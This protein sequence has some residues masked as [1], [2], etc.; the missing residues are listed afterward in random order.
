MPPGGLSAAATFGSVDDL[1]TA[2]QKRQFEAKPA[3]AALRRMLLVHIYGPRCA[4][5]EGKNIRVRFRP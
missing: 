2:L 1:V 5:W 3:L 4:L